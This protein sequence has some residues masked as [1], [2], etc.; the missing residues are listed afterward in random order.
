MIF[1]WYN[2][3]DV[4]PLF[5]FGH[6][7]S[8]TQFLYSGLSVKKSTGSATEIVGVDLSIRNIGDKEGSEVVQL[9]ISFP[10]EARE[11]KRQLKGFVKTTSLSTTGSESSIDVHFGL[12]A[13]DLSIWDADTHQWTLVSGMYVVEV[14]AS[15]ADIRITNQFYL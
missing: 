11:P 10:V 13:R 1:R 4:R 6:G 7:L 5:P 12:T 14:G 8:Y 3:K 2:A 9:Y 15:S